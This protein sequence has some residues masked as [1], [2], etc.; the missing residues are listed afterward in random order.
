MKYN[1]YKFMNNDNVPKN[2]DDYVNIDPYV[3]LI[4][5]NSK[6]ITK[7]VKEYNPFVV[8]NEDNF[9]T[10][11]LPFEYIYQMSEIK[12]NLK[13]DK[14]NYYF[15]FLYRN[16]NVE[17]FS[18]YRNENIIYS[19]SDIEDIVDII[20][21][22]S[23]KSFI[24]HKDLY[25]LGDGISID[26]EMKLIEF[27]DHY[28]SH[29]VTNP[30]YDA[31][32][33]IDKIVLKPL[34]SDGNLYK[35]SC[36]GI[37]NDGRYSLLS[38]V[39]SVLLKYNEGEISTKIY[40]KENESGDNEY[41]LYKSSMYDKDIEIKKEDLHS[42]IVP[43][44]HSHEIYNNDMNVKYANERLLILP[45]IWH[46]DKAYL[47]Y[48]SYR[49]FKVHN[50]KLDDECYNDFIFHKDGDSKISIDMMVVLKKD[51][52]HLKDT[53]KNIPL[54][55]NDANVEIIKKIIKIGGIFYEEEII[56]ESI[57]KEFIH[58]CSKDPI[59]CI[60]DSVMSNRIYNYTI[61]LYDQYKE[62]S[63]AIVRVI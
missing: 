42:R 49:I 46:K 33:M 15:K 29:G 11:S 1:I 52:T 4:E 22:N 53:D 39:S 19:N 20:Y 3:E 45:N 7:Q 48:R 57:N 37:H 14:Y 50:Y 63:K 36:V 62:R 8:E 27:V 17:E 34:K 43:T 26:F 51:V 5:K 58:S 32:E 10:V 23:G 24:M 54:D 31:I 6:I 61:Y 18:L 35:Y 56:D 2:L 21:V 38:N 60:N 9:I 59:I 12:V 25:N 30:K 13:H 16:G 55:Y 41:F 44:F 47:H 40:I 28:D